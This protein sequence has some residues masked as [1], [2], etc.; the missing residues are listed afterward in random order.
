M[1][2]TARKTADS[3]IVR[4]GG[5]SMVVSGVTVSSRVGFRSVN[6]ACVAQ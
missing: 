5:R 6:L 2:R 3:S 1:G 4:A